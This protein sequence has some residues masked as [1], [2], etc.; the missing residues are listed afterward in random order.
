MKTHTPTCGSGEPSLH[1]EEILDLHARLLRDKKKP[2]KAFHPVPLLIVFLFGGILFWA[3]LAVSLQTGFWNPD[4]YDIHWEKGSALAEHAKEDGSGQP[5]KSIAFRKGKKLYGTPGACVT[6]HQK[7]GQGLSPTFPPLA[8]SEWVSGSPEV[9]SRIVLHGLNGPITVK[10]QEYNNIMAVTVWKSWSDVDIANVL[11][12]IRNEWGNEASE[13][14][15]EIVT[16]IR[17]EIGE[18]GPWTAEELKGL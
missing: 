14:D 16:K 6:C 13:I 17:D 4:V 10:G 2:I 9:L 5:K 15:V 3:G 1:D 12:Y 7:N 18:R 11:S 8:G